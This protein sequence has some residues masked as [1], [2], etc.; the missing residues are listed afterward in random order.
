MTREENEK[1]ARGSDMKRTPPMEVDDE[2]VQAFCSIA[3]K[4]FKS[5]DT[6]LQEAQGG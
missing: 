6:E 5:R 1:E 3:Q 2:R 4:H